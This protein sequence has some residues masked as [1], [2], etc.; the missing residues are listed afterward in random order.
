MTTLSIG[1]VCYASDE[2]ALKQTLVSLRD[3]CLRAHADGRL[4]SASL[5]LFDNGP[6][7]SEHNKIESLIS[8]CIVPSGAVLTA[9]ILGDGTNLG[10]GAAHNLA[11]KQAS[12]DLHLI[13]NPDVDL[14]G[15]ALSEALRFM[16]DHLGCGVLAPAV[17]N[18]SGSRE[19]LCK[20]YPTVFD[21]FL[22]GFAP[23][24]LKQKFE[25]HLAAYEM[26]DMQQ[27][28]IY[29]NP[30]IISGCFM[31]FRTSV[32]KELG[33]FDSSYFLYFEDFDLSLRTAAVSR[34]AYVPTVK[35]M[36]A[37]GHASRKG[38]RHIF[39]FFRSALIFFNRHGWKW[40]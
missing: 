23:A 1:L 34:I 3:A 32:L 19:Y 28:E 37:G 14:A 35:I 22:R 4:S 36:H 5:V 20:R 27:E 26:R 8:D 10:F 17:A 31:L 2:P 38:W 12:A 15:D 9:S 25:K 7:P 18:S 16:Q 30:P 39:L 29:W 13:L 24:W 33:G 40:Y 6:V 11:F 21:L